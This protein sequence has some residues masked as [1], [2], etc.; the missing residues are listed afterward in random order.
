MISIS[1]D[2]FIQTIEQ[3][4]LQYR[5]LFKKRSFDIFFWLMLAIISVEEVRSIRFLHENFIKKYS[6]KALNSLYYVLSYIHFPTEE[7]LKI[8]V[9]IAVSL[10]PDT[11][12]NS[13]IFLTIDDTLQVKFGDHFDCYF[14]HFD[15]ANKTGSSYLQGHCF[16]SLIINIP[17]SYQGKTRILSLPVG[18]RLYTKDKSKLQIASEMI[19]SAMEYLKDFQVILLCDSWYS[20]GIIIETVKNYNNLDLIAAVRSDTALFDLP[21]A[22]TGKRGRPRVHGDKL[23]KTTFSFEKLG[24]YYVSK[25]QAMTRLFDQPVYVTVTTTNPEELTSVRV[26]ISTL[27]PEEVQLFKD[28]EQEESNSSFK[29]SENLTLRAYG[30]RWNIEVIFYQ[31]KFFWGFSNY[32]VRNKLAIERYVNLLAIGFTLVSVLPFLDQ[33]LKAWQFESP[34]IIKREIASQIHKELILSSFVSS[35]ENSKIYSSIK[36]SVR[37]YLEGRKIA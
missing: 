37:C 13:T 33:R 12:K 1:K 19:D 36:E 14:Q 11:L 2:S 22:P 5:S 4:L 26:Y 29:G 6:K 34:Q 35:L 31:Q 30:I 20:K 8:T 3:Y 7:L 27:N 9:G 17:L 25:K 21:P 16:V 23:D 10:I 32:M 24:D 18:Y 28:H 15:H